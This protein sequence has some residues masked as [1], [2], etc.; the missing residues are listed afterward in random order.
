VFTLAVADLTVQEMRDKVLNKP[1]LARNISVTRLEAFEAFLRDYSELIAV[2]SV[3][4]RITRD[5]RDDYLLCP[6]VIERV[7]YVVTGDKDLL[8]LGSYRGVHIVTPREFVILLALQ[9]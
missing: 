5:P 1:Y 4:S 9:D 7:D 3:I 6:A 2:P 8:V